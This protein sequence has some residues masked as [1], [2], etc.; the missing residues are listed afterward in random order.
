[1]AD[2]RL[3]YFDLDDESLKS[4]ASGRKLEVLIHYGFM[5]LAPRQLLLP[6]ATAKKR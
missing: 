3:G 4:I 1:M 5:L 6:L 2:A